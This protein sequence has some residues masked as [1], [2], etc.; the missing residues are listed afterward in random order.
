MRR[1]LDVARVGR[2][3]ETAHLQVLPAPPSVAGSEEPHPERDDGGVGRRRADRD[4]VA[5]QH[6]FRVGLLLHDGAPKVGPIREPHEVLAQVLP[7]LSPVG[8]SHRP[9]DLE[10]GVDLLRP[11]GA[12]RHPHHPRRD[13]AFD[14]LPDPGRRQT[15]PARPA[16]LRAPDAEWRYAGIHPVRGIVDGEEAPDLAAAVRKVGAPEARPP[17]GAAPHPVDGAGEHEAGLLGMHEDRVNLR[18][19][20]HVLPLAAVRAPTEHADRAGVAG[21]A[22]VARHAGVDVGMRHGNL[23]SRFVP[24]HAG[25]NLSASGPQGIRRRTGRLKWGGH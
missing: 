12:L 10:R 14:P 1:G 6:A 22:E 11:P 17:V 5:V 3:R 18:G 4:R 13:G 25:P 15:A 7:G 20:E 24:G 9:R 16:I 23:P 8:R 19:G 21:P 2:G